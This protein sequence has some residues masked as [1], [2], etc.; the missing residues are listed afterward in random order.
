MATHGQIGTMATKEATMAQHAIQALALGCLY[1]L[2]AAGLAFMSN[3][4]RTLYLAYGGLYL[5]GAFVTWWTLRSSLPIWMALALAPL[6]C[7]V[8]GSALMGL[9]RVAQARRSEQAQLLW[10]L[11]IL[12]CS[13]EGY[14]LV[15]ESYHRKVIAIDSH[16]I[17]YLGPLMLSDMHWLVFGCT[18]G[19][20]V[21]IQ[22]FLTT[23]RPGLALLAA[24]DNPDA[25]SRWRGLEP[26]LYGAA[27]GAALAGLGGGL[28]ALHFNDVHPEMGLRLIH[29]LLCLVII[30]GL[31]RIR[32]AVLAA[33]G[34]AC[35]EE[36]FASTTLDLP[37]P[38]E[39]FLLI[40]LFVVSLWGR[41]HKALP[42]GLARTKEC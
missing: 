24:L 40:A 30:G 9:E 18:F 8:L 17:H 12:V 3:A 6:F 22:G 36:I 32:G 1:A 16:Q 11:G 25:L 26:R 37:L 14:R 29:K 4:R 2:L 31:G 41:R 23:S 19:F 38:A 7:V 34:L 39:I 27:I 28:A 10:G 33:F 13:M 15:M 21:A 20:G 42:R 5:V 35:I